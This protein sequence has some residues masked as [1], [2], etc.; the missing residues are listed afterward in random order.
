[1]LFFISFFIFLKIIFSE[2]SCK[3]GINNC[4]KCNPITKLCIKCVKDIYSPNK[5]GGCENSKKCILGNNHCLECLED[6]GLCKECDEGY[7]PDENGGCSITNNCEISYKGECLKCKENFILIGRINYY[8]YLSDKNK[9]CKPYNSDDLQNCKSINLQKGK[10]E[11]CNEGYFHSTVDQKCTKIKNCAISSFG[12]CKNCIYGYYLNKKEQK[13]IQQNDKFLNCKISNDGQKC[14]EC[15]DDYYFDKEG[16]CVYSNYCALGDSYKCEK[17]IDGYYLTKYGGI[18]TTEENC[19]GGRKDIGICTSCNDNY[20][21]DFNDGKCKSNQEDN[22]LKN[23]RIAE[24]KCIECQYGFYLGQ[25]DQKCCNSMNCLKSENGICSECKN[26][27]HLGLDKKCTSVE[28]CIY[29]DDY[30][31]CIQCENNYFYDKGVQKCK[32]AEGKFKNCKYGYED[33]YCEKCNDNFYINKNDNLCYSNQENNNFYKCEMSSND[34]TYCIQCIDNYF[35]GH[36][37]HKCTKAQY[38]SIVENDE[39]CLVCDEAYCLDAKDG[40]CEDN[41]IINDLEK[42]FYFRCNKTNIESTSCEICLE[43]YELKNGLCL[44]DFHC[45]ERNQDGTCKRCRKAEDE[46]YEQCLSDTFGCIEAYFDENCLECN[47]LLEIGDCTKCIDGFKL[48][49]NKK[50]YEIDEENK[51]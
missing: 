23:C 32:L 5:D 42:K 4:S 26:D 24:G 43:G 31:N 33:K 48:D 40:R 39:R 1:M 13:C 10:C 8:T 14:D 6:E 38:C 25:L 49:N 11:E 37:D 29:T 12:I 27:F 44:D 19:Y 47:D 20:C 36:I 22:D 15:Y 16:K 2:P 28:H 9:L 17:C 51:Y 35:L 30:Y 41:D 3:A 46:Y 18:C 45:S 21:I 50:C 34:G 7:F